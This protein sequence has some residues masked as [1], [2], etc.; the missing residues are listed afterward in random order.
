MSARIRLTRHGKKGY[1]FYHIVVA[2]IRAPRDGRFIERL[3]FYNPNTDPASVE[4]NFEKSLTWLENGAQPTDTVRNLFSNE[5][6]L[7]RYHLLRGVA[8]GAITQEVADA[9]FDAWKEEKV[10]KLARKKEQ[11]EEIM[12]R[13]EKKRFEHETKVRVAR[14]EAQARRNAERTAKKSEE[15]AEE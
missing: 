2:D 7:Y 5:G 1:P 10:K 13:E 11:K 9:K 3:G 4:L 14:T 15:P 12:K 6:V 8:K